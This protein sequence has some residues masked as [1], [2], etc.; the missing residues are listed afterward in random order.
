MKLSLRQLFT[1]LAA[2]S[3]LSLFLTSSATAAALD[4]GYPEGDAAPGRTCAAEAV[5]QKTTSSYSGKNLSC[6]LIY[7]IAKWWV[8][9]DPLPAVE[10]PAAK[11]TASAQPTAPASAGNQ[12]VLEKGVKIT[13]K[14]GSKLIKVGDARPAQ[15]LIPG[16]LKAKVAAPLLVALPGFTATPND[17]L[18]LVDLTAEAYKRGVVLALPSGSKNSGGLPFWNATG[19]CCDFEKS[20]VDDSKYLMDLVKQISA[21]VSIDA[22][23]VYFFGHSN[24]GFM[25]YTTAC[26]NSSKIAALV[27]F[28]GSS[29]ADMSLCKADRPVSVLQI[30]GTE[31]E[32]IHIVGG[33]VFDDPKQPYSSVAVETGKWAEINGCSTSTALIKNKTKFNYE[34]VLAGSETTKAAYKCPKGVAVEMWTIAGGKHLPKIN[35]EFISSVFDF[36]LAHKK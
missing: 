7:G 20:G 6:I 1:V 27:N 24:G 30:N 35:A 18:A 36:L 13:L 2:G 32:L 31:D 14:K 26:N 15:V 11:P 17:L 4:D 8:D 23:R 29:F 34:S 9:G 19:S 28:N 16:T 33:N 12:F 5:G 22:K 21:K 3:L 10:T 25:S